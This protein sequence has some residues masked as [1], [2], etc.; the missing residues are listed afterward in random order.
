[1]GHSAHPPPYLTSPPLNWTSCRKRSETLTDLVNW[2]HPN[3]SESWTAWLSV[4]H[5]ART[6]STTMTW[7]STPLTGSSL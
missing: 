5:T 4:T 7:T 6:S 1:M 3:P 2:E